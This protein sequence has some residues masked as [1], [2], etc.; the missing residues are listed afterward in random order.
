M[1]SFRI[2]RG[3]A[4]IGKDVL[5]GED[6][7]RVGRAQ[8]HNILRT[9]SSEAIKGAARAFQISNSGPREVY[10][11]FKAADWVYENRNRVREYLTCIDSGDYRKLRAMLGEDLRSLISRGESGLAD[12]IVTRVIPAEAR[13]VAGAVMSSIR[14]GSSSRLL[15]ET[16]L[17]RRTRPKLPDWLRYKP[18]RMV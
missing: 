15:R 4:K 14:A 10:L 11:G 3:L 6:V 13:P 9:P 2:R 7:L 1:D 8:R 5:P 12:F 16:P 17:S 18:A